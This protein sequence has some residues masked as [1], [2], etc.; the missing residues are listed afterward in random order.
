MKEIMAG[1]NQGSLFIVVNFQKYCGTVTR[2][3]S[4]FAVICDKA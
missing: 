4:Y 1:H 2:N 3:L